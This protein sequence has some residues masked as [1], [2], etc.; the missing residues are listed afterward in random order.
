MI[1]LRLLGPKGVAGIAV[2]LCLS[3]LLLLQKAE[4]R[5]WRDRSVENE[6]LYRAEQAALAGTIA[7]YR[8]A[9]DVARAA[10][11]AIADR[12]AAEQSAINER[13]AH[14]YEARIAAARAVAQRLRGGASS[15][16]DP[17]PRGNAD[18]PG[19]SATPGRLAQGAGE[20]RLPATDAL[21]AT[22]QAIQLDEL[23][24]WVREQHGVKS[25]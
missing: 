21:I 12:V 19:L 10:D 20:D 4:T 1:L 13:T 15:E 6:R 25:Q 14:D 24:D 3:L 8:T 22:E 9:A 5:R 16:A 2:A 23:I 7:N 11:R 18:L 17:G